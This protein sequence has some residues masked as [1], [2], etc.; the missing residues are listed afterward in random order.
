MRLSKEARK[1][2]NY[3][4]HPKRS[5]HEIEE[6]ISEALYKSHQLDARDI[7]VKVSQGKITLS[8]SVMDEDSALS[9]VSTVKELLGFADVENQL[10]F[11]KDEHPS[12]K[13]TGEF[14]LRH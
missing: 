10:H 14:K 8:G 13:N 9:A 3:N 1:V 5:D 11:R 2:N 7:M 4:E 12:H 6:Q